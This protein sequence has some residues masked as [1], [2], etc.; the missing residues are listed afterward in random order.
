MTDLLLNA[1]PLELTARI[2]SILSL[3]SALWL[4]TAYRRRVASVGDAIRRQTAEP[5]NPTPKPGN[6]PAVSVVIVAGDN[7][8]A[9]QTLLDKIF[10]Q[11]YAGEMEVIVVN[12]GKNDD[13]KDVVTRIKHLEHRPNLFITFTPPGLRNVSHRKLALTLGVKAARNPVILTLTE[14]S[15]LYSTRWLAL[16]AEPFA[17]EGVELVIGSALPGHKFDSGHGQRYRSFTHGHDAVSWLSAA[18][19]G[20]PWRG[21]RANMGFT[22]RAFFDAGGFNGAL[23]LRDGDDDI[24]ISK[25]VHPGNFEVVCAAQAAVRYARPTSRQQFREGRSQRMFTGRGLG[26]STARFFGFSS[27]MAWMLLLAS[28]GAIAAGILT[29]DWLATA[30]SA[31]LLIVTCVVLSLT[32][33]ST[34]KALR[35]RPAAAGVFPMMLRRPFTNAVHR[36][37]SRRN[38]NEYYTWAS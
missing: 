38:R 22:R 31:S 19:G 14:E 10:I 33:R 12:D 32:W 8:E 1:S 34:L 27:A 13:I 5:F 17:R 7:A 35:C 2:L 28:A 37:R 15:R 11:E 20:K 30:L 23:N 9:L 36:L 24:F 25:I 26:R 4:L 21:H 6:L 3:L 29:R 18:L 16:M